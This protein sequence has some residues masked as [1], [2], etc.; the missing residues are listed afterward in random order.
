MT[1]Q[2]ETIDIGTAAQ[3]KIVLD[4]I[5]RTFSGALAEA[6]AA[7]TFDAT[8]IEKLRDIWTGKQWSQK[9]SLTPKV[10]SLLS[11]AELRS[12]GFREFEEG[13]VLIPLSMW[14]YIEDGCELISINGAIYVKREGDH[15]QSLRMYMTAYGFL[16]DHDEHVKYVDMLKTRKRE[17][18]QGK[19]ATDD[20]PMCGG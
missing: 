18:D 3:L 6:L 4:T 11:T 15:Q 16:H 19:V 20:L 14:N 1:H 2:I 5:S 12:Y 17:I 13:F 10:L 8:K 9:V 7:D